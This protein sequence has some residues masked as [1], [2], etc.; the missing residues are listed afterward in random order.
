MEKPPLKKTKKVKQLKLL[1]TNYSGI[2][3]KIWG[4][5]REEWFPDN[6]GIIITEDGGIILIDGHESYRYDKTAD[7]EDEQ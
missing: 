3:A 1:S 6:S 5:P 2:F 7:S 4:E